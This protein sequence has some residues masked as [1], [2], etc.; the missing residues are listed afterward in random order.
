METDL[1]VG[2]GGVVGGPAIKDIMIY[3]FYFG[4]ILSTLDLQKYFYAE[5]VATRL[6]SVK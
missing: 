5:L 3:N 2:Y 1:F 4:C 6:F